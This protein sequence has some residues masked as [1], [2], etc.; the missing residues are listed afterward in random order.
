MDVSPRLVDT[1]HGFI[2]RHNGCYTELSL[3]VVN[4]NHRPALRGS[5]QVPD[6][7][8]SWYLLKVGVS[9]GGSACDRPME[10]EVGIQSSSPHSVY[11]AIDEV[12]D[13]NIDPTVLED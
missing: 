13:L 1:P 8:V 11:P 3:G 4:L 6:D 9:A 12:R 2:P 5:N 10:L 7:G